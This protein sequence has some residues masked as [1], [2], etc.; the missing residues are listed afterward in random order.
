MQ[1]GDAAQS[2]SVQS[3][4]II[5][6][7]GEGTM[8]LCSVIQ[9]VPCSM[10]QIYICIYV[11]CGIGVAVGL[12]CFIGSRSSRRILGGVGWWCGGV[13]RF[14]YWFTGLLWV[15]GELRRN[16]RI[17]NIDLNF[18]LYRKPNRMRNQ[19]CPTP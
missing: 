6:W 19:F 2:I 13:N 3:N 16:S 9:G 4:P 11:L 5:E 14:V 7:N 12:G 15:R 1:C 18:Y 10:L 17:I 8:A